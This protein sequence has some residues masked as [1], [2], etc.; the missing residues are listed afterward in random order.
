MTPKLPGAPG[1]KVDKVDP[2][3]L[4]LS[5]F[6]ILRFLLFSL[7]ELATVTVCGRPIHFYLIA[8]LIVAGHQISLIS[9]VKLLFSRSSV[10]FSCSADTALPTHDDAAFDHRL[11]LPLPPPR[12]WRRGRGL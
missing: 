12:P 4:L 1:Y 9:W 2:W 11:A 7:L 8:D 10:I 3:I 6:S 5:L